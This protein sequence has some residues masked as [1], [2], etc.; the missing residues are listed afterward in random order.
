MYWK[1]LR[2]TCENGLGIWKERERKGWLKECIGQMWRVTEVKGDHR[3]DGG[4][5]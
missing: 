4:M 5:K 1:E 2:G 3:E